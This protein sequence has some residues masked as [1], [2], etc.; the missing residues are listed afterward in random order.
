MYGNESNINK[1]RVVQLPPDRR[2][3]EIEYLP[4]ELTINELL[5]N[6]NE[7]SSAFPERDLIQVT[8][9][10]ELKGYDNKTILA[11]IISNTSTKPI[12]SIAFRIIA[13]SD[14][15]AVLWD[16]IIRIMIAINPSSSEPFHL[17]LTEIDNVA[18]ISWIIKE[19]RG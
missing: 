15:E 13:K 3:D 19:V 14:K 7:P 1:I 8:G 4:E 11:G 16:R 5:R 10:A 2:K 9:N 6:Q 17:P 12:T 18:T